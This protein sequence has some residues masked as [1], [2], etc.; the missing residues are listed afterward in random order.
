MA[1]EE[2]EEDYFFDAT[3]KSD[4][5]IVEGVR[6]KLYLPPTHI[7][8]ISL[9][10]HV[11]DEQARLLEGVG[12]KYSVHGELH[13][14]VDQV[15]TFHAEQVLNRGLSS[16]YTAGISENSFAGEPIFLEVTE[17]FRSSECPQAE[18]EINGNFWLTPN[19]LLSPSQRVVK[20]YTGNI[21]VK[22]DW[23]LGFTLQNDVGL[24]FTNHYRYQEDDAGTL[25]SFHE[26]VAEF[27]SKS[28][29]IGYAEVR[30]PI[31]REL[32]DLLTLASFAAR[33]GCVWMGYAVTSAKGYT[34]Y[35]RR[36]VSI[37]APKKR[38][39]DT[40]I[41]KKDIKDF[42]DLTCRKLVEVG[43][44]DLLIKA[45]NFATPKE[46]Q[47]FEGAFMA[48]YSALE[49][50]VLYFRRGHNLEMIFSDDKDAWR[51]L[52]ADLRLWLR[53]HPQLKD[54]KS[55]RTL[56]YENLPALTRVSFRNAF[57]KFCEFYSVKLDD[58]WPVVE[59]ADGWSLAIIRNR[60][61]HG[62]YFNRQQ[63]KALVSAGE[64]L[65]W[66][67]ER[68]ILS[69]FGWDVSRSMVSTDEL[70]NRRQYKYWR[71]DRKLLSS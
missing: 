5:I 2:R 20:S 64:H 49:T 9:V 70:S 7:G 33:R 27:E 45:I 19:Q 57:Q 41:A 34:R 42:L 69:I 6:C 37:P 48:L 13:H 44:N 15:T 12:W 17:G 62:E 36:D 71:E 28:K 53:R 66:T 30:G 1:R 18:C 16:K 52:E 63:Q 29:T 10:F 35:Y 24:T 39:G 4:T 68:M 11:T 46:G 26:L 32:E 38:W 54:D 31:V 59:S 65:R 67:V 25:T 60:L 61:V 50:L 21:N 55:K 58:L 40:L 56:L 43:R 3:I 8:P 14:D 22:T 51:R 23:I 47:V